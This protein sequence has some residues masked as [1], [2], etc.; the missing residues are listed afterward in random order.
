M[1]KFLVVPVIIL[2]M[3]MV[4]SVQAATEQ[5]AWDAIFAA[6]DAR[7]VAD[8]KRDDCDDMR[9]DDAA[10]SEHAALLLLYTA[11]AGTDKD[12]GDYDVGIAEDYGDDAA[13]DQILGRVD[14]IDADADAD[15]GVTAFL[16]EDWEACITHFNNAEVHYDD[17]Y[18]DFV[19]AL[20]DFSNADIYFQFAK[21]YY[22][23]AQP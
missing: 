19:A 23:L 20:S 8:A 13:D 17:S 9:D 16:A 7:D 4:S 14:D 22:G 12:D 15:L 21:Y 18:D 3:L 10:E 6:A 5:D 11:E 2:A 1:K